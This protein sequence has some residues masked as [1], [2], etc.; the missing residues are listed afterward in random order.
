MRRW[1]YRSVQGSRGSGL[2]CGSGWS[3]TYRPAGWRASAACQPTR[4]RRAASS[5]TGSCACRGPGGGADWPT[6]YGGYGATLL[7]Q[8]I[9]E[10]EIARREAPPFANIV[11][12]G[13]V[14]PTLMALGAPEQKA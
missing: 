12:T 9:Y 10:E 13:L 3:R 1:T 14:R 5:A 8:L 6:E 7:E 4:P 11:G 2:R